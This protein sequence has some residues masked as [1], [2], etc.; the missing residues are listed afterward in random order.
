MPSTD[1]RQEFDWVNDVLA[2]W[3]ALPEQAWFEKSPSLDR[4]CAVRFGQVHQIVSELS[5][6]QVTAT[7]RQ[8]LAGVI[9]L[10]Q[11]SRNMFRDT[12][13]AFAFDDKARAVAEQALDRGLDRDLSQNERLFLY[14]PFEHSE[15]LADQER[16]VSLFKEL[17]HEDYARYAI[18]HRDIIARFGRFPHRNGILGRASTAEEEAFLQ[19]PGSSF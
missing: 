4:E 7:A 10:D 1:A 6:D 5:I 11:F 2:F 16:S 12:P 13:R 18:A 19:Q 17:G 15:S 9:V 3:F 14:L 8:A